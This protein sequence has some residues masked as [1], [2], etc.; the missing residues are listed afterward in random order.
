MSIPQTLRGHP[1][2]TYVFRDEDE[3]RTAARGAWDYSNEDVSSAPLLT[4][5][6]LL[7]DARKVVPPGVTG[8]YF[9]LTEGRVAY[10]GLAKDFA[11]RLVGHWSSGRR[12]FEFAFVTCRPDQ[13]GVLEKRYIIEFWPE[14]NIRGKPTGHEKWG[15]QSKFCEACRA[16]FRRLFGHWHACP[17]C[18]HYNWIGFS[19]DEKPHPDTLAPYE[20]EAAYRVSLSMYP[21]EQNGMPLEA[22]KIRLPKK[23]KKTP[24]Q[25]F[26]RPSLF[27]LNCFAAY[28]S[29]RVA[30]EQIAAPVELFARWL[31]GATP[32]PDIHAT[33][34]RARE[35]V[36]KREKNPEAP[37]SYSVV[38]DKRWFATISD[39]AHHFRITPRQATNRAQQ[40]LQGWYFVP[41]GFRP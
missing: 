36:R 10:V 5:R 26:V 23:P 37:A 30:C 6:D 15:W 38:V 28:G 27:A 24:R 25:K 16:S 13:M 29:L 39:A 1:S 35:S 9:Y 31:A 3:R 2:S 7:D 4:L 21:L 17:R 34:W 11:K 12:I 22:P 19:G 41:Y 14:Q 20:R 33:V 18:G 40:G 32:P 8:V